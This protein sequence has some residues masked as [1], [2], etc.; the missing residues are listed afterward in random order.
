MPFT[1]FPPHFR[2][3]GS[4][5]LGSSPS[6]LSTPFPPVTKDDWNLHERSL[7]W[8]EGWEQP[9]WTEWEGVRTW[10]ER[11]EPPRV[12][13][14]TRDP[15]PNP[16]SFLP[17]HPRPNDPGSARHL[18]WF[19]REMMR[20]EGVE[21]R[22]LR[23]TPDSERR[24]RRAKE[25]TDAPP[26]HRLLT[27]HVSSVLFV[28]RLATLA[29]PLRSLPRV[30]RRRSRRWTGGSGRSERRVHGILLASESLM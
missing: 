22:R 26:H 30:S 24:E 6:A 23:P 8:G 28:S 25:V 19:G 14:A 7:S 2:S 12:S 4:I 27:S 13:L 1:L 18:R 5:A 20:W 21:E 29:S 9:R 3:S 15:H 10:G 11:S 17:S 16:F